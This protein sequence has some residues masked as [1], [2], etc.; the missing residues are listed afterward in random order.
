[1]SFC[2]LEMSFSLSE[3]SFCLF[4]VLFFVNFDNFV[5][6]YKQLMKISKCR[7]LLMTFKFLP[8]HFCNQYVQHQRKKL[9]FLDS[10]NEFCAFEKVLELDEMRLGFRKM[11]FGLR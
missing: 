1:M 10:G 6:I 11:S 8:C 7:V 4:D 5:M 9:V 2:L 3:M